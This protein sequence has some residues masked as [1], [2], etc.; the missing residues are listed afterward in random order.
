MP[1]SSSSS[2]NLDARS[3][4]SNSGSSNGRSL[5][6]ENP[7]P[8]KVVIALEASQASMDDAEVGSP[9]CPHGLGLATLIVES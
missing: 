3:S 4:G 5:V 1:S 8:N 6:G 2:S 9:K 7:L